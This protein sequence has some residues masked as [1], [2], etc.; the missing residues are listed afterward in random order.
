MYDDTLSR[1]AVEALA[2]AGLQSSE[3]MCGGSTLQTTVEPRMQQA[4]RDEMQ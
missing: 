3:K 1:V 4:Q 2:W